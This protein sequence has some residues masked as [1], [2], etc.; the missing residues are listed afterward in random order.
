[1]ESG[2]NRFSEHQC[3]GRLHVRRKGFEA[4]ISHVSD[5][6][7]ACYIVETGTSRIKDNWEGDGQ[8]TLI[9]DWLV[10]EKKAFDE[11]LKIISIDISTEAVLNSAE[12]TRNVEYLIGDSIQALSGLSDDIVENIRLLYLDSFDW[13]PDLH[14]DSAFH[15]FMELAA[16]YAKLPKNAMVMVDD[17]HGEEA[18]KHHLIKIFF[19]KLNIKPFYSGYQ[20]AWIKP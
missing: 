16:V 14:L 18:G 9:W 13:H 3:Y 6:S 20:I 2:L 7:E 10:E 5:F 17:R 8:S 11:T 4:A 12:Q 1:M 15:H 19:E